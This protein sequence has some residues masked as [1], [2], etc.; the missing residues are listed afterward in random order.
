M[1]HP[2][3][4]FDA[5]MYPLEALSLRRKR[6][7]LLARA[8]GDVLEIGAGTGVN[9]GYYD[10]LAVASITM[11]DL[12]VGERLRERAASFGRGSGAT[13]V[14]LCEADAMNLPFA[15][16][17]FD[18]VVITLVFCSVPEQAIGF[19]EVR[20]V[21]RPGGQMLFIEHVRPHHRVRHLVDRL[22]PLWFRVTRECNINRETA[23]AMQSS[24]F[25]I[26]E[27]T[28]SGRGFLIHGVAR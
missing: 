3:T 17:A 2:D 9:F 10:T 16:D 21:L 13:P 7:I 28:V 1:N 11:S 27:L 22:N 5:V 25:R 23:T 24:G 14:H 8:R 15:D 18:T 6:R 20:R 4:L 19:S 26:D 12:S